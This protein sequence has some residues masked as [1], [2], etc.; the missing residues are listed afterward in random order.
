MSAPARTGAHERSAQDK[1]AAVFGGEGHLS[2]DLWIYGSMDLWIYGS[3][4]LSISLSLYIHIY[5]Y[6]Y[7]YIYI[8][9]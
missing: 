9:I 6:M 8:Y 2:M 5:T 1:H 4:D 7:T 3:M